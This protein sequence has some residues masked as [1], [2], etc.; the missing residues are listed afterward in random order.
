LGEFFHLNKGEIMSKLEDTLT[1][2]VLITHQQKVADLVLKQLFT[3]DPFS[4]VAGGAP[5]DWY[6]G[7]PATDIDAFFYDARNLTLPKMQSVLEA[8]GFKVE[9]CQQGGN[10]PDWYNKNPDLKTVY[11]LNMSGVKVQ[12]MRMSKPTFNC[13]LPNFPLSICH[14]WYKEG[15]IF[16][17]KPFI[18]SVQHKVIYKTSGIY[19]NEHRYIKKILDK[20]PDYK[21][22]NSSLELVEYILDNN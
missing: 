3:I 4:I 17:E 15:K 10:L 12:I 20:F 21:Y 9:S 1:D 18:R 11:N 22:Y 19:N 8:V 16:T 14:V 7:K 13:V 6:L 5:R 2:S